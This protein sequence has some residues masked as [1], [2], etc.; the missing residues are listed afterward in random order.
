MLYHISYDKVR[1]NTFMPRVPKQRAPGED[2]KIKRVCFSDS[3]EG[4]FSAMPQGGQSLRGYLQIC[5]KKGLPPF[6][7]LYQLDEKIEK[8][9]RMSPKQISR[10]C[11][12]SLLTGENWILEK[13]TIKPR[14]IE[15]AEAHF[16][17]EVDRNGN[18]V[19][20]VH[21]VRYK[22]LRFEP[23]RSMQNI[24]GNHS[25]KWSFRSAMAYLDYKNLNNG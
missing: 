18:K 13:I 20:V 8:V 6:V 22:N 9:E 14:V 16:N 7:Y 17:D 25:S 1:N 12:D 3:I 21:G 10:Y 19:V 24:L 4:C 2:K 23:R 5:A 15:I 11:C